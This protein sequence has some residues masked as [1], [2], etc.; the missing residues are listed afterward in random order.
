MVL[1]HMAGPFCWLTY[2]GLFG[3][4]ALGPSS[5][6]LHLG[7]V[8]HEIS[9][10]EVCCF[11]MNSACMSSCWQGL[12]ENVC[13]NILWIYMWLSL[14]LLC[15]A[16]TAQH[17]SGFF[18]G[19]LVAMPKRQIM[20]TMLPNWRLLWGVMLHTA[21]ISTSAMGMTPLWSRTD[22]A[23]RSGLWRSEHLAPCGA[24]LHW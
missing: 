9:S 24:A 4:M 10:D 2:M 7:C 21:R 8:T 22:A 14:F 11:T 23:M 15:F 1:I 20:W 18:A 5:G 17:L 12:D 16:R 3:E 6:W 13:L 19:S